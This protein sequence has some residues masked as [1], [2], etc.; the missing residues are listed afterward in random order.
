MSNG[1]RSAAPEPGCMRSPL[2]QAAW[3]HHIAGLAIAIGCGAAPA[4]ALPPGCAEAPPLPESRLAC[5]YQTDMSYRPGEIDL[6]LLHD[7]NRNNYPV[8]LKVRFP[9]GATLPRPVI[10]WHHGGD[11]HPEGRQRSMEWG[12]ALARAGYVVVHPSRVQVSAFTEHDVGECRRNGFLPSSG[13]PTAEE[14]QA[15]V[16][17]LSQARYG[18]QNTHFILSRLR[19]LPAPVA[20]LFDLSRVAVA[21]HSAGTMAVQANAG[22]WQQWASHRYSERVEGA[23]AF[24]GTGMQGPAYAGFING[25]QHDSYYGVDRPMLTISGR[26]DYTGEPSASKAAAWLM[27]ARNH[28]FLSWASSL[29]AVHETMDIDKCDGPVR[30]LHCRW[31]E[32][33]GVAFMDAHL[34][35]RQEAIDWLASDAYARMT[36]GT[37]DLQRR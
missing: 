36:L 17:W 6:D 28:K 34:R 22:A 9:I 12:K 32:S 10:I 5:A 30:A 13:Q 26:G 27:S 20:R 2:R 18:P 21:G 1:Q 33:L 19:N 14:R 23:R 31:F 11:P 16:K 24:M 15:C 7:P 8:P 25:F 37:V 3:L 35:E 4:Q 29:D